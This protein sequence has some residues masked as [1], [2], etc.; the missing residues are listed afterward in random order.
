VKP[1]SFE[2]VEPDDLD[3]AVELLAGDE[4]ARPLA[5]GQSLVPMLN[6]RLVH[7]STLVGL[8]RLPG[9]N[10]IERRDGEL[11]IGAMVSQSE[12]IRSAEVASACPLVR[13]ALTLIGHPQI[14]SRGTVGGSLA[15][16]DPAAELPAVL[17]AL[18]G[19]VTVHGPR[20]E[21]SIAASD[22]VQGYYTT[23]LA[24]GEILTEA[25]FPLLPPRTGAACVELARRP[26]DF[27]SAGAACRLTLAE[28]GA[29]TEARVA[30]FAV[31][32]GPVRARAAEEALVGARPGDEAWRAAAAVTCE[33]WNARAAESEEGRYRTRVAPTIVARALALAA[34]RAA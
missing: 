14:R 5:G 18:D 12:A 16:A 1:P 30:L 29:V 27:A 20:G 7:P 15:H 3:S 24:T 31:A 9:L 32:D 23:S 11:A 13:E 25:R 33:G 6:F 22:L 26:G 19:A 10:G 34:E 17:L 2:Y 4:D 28:D 8:R 21:R